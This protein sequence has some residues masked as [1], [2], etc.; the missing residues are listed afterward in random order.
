MKAKILNL[1][2]RE[3]SALDW[4][5]ARL[6]ALEAIASGHQLL[7]HLDLGLFQEL[8]RPLSHS[9][10][11]LNLALALD[12]FKDKIWKEF[13][14][15]SGGVALYNGSANFAITLDEEQ[16]FNY[17]AWLKERS[18]E[19]NPFVKQL[20]ARDVAAEYLEQL[21]ERLPDEIEPHIILELP[22]DPLL[23]A[24][25]TD[26]SRYGR[27]KVQSPFNWR[28]EES[29]PK[30]ICMPPLTAVNPTLLAPLNKILA[31]SSDYKLIPEAVLTQVWD[32]LDTLIYLPELISPQGERKI[33]GFQAA[34]GT[35]IPI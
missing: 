12:H 19:N 4:T 27:I 21:V 11:F 3:N 17:Q 23:K 26:P 15:F 34:G 30:A 18:V 8:T 20:F 7:W 31:D 13:H 33:K 25:L 24:L 9:V 32:G 14:R 1:D 22:E 16:G 10:Q 28:T 5:E 29:L 2:A 6:E 35:I